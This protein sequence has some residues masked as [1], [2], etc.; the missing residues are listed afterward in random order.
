MVIDHLFKAVNFGLSDETQVLLLM[1]GRMAFPFFAWELVECF[2]FTK[3]K[4]KH[5]FSIGLLAT[6]SE[7]PYDRAIR[8]SW[9][10]WNRQNIC[11]TLFL[12]WLMLMLLHADWNK[13]YTNLGMTKDTKLKRAFAK[14]SGLSMAAPI[15]WVAGKTQA[16]YVWWGIGFVLLLDFAH[17][18]KF[19]KVW[20]FIT[21]VTYIGCMGLEDSIMRMVYMPCFFCLIFMWLAELDAKKPQK[22]NEFVSKMLLSKTS[23]T[24]CR[25]FYPAHLIILLILKGVLH[26]L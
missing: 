9:F 20:E 23:K 21:I 2:H 1:I 8:N 19:R 25:Y 3:N 4:W 18:R 24:I 11:L 13:I 16:D 10:D 14:M 6:V 12:S 17:S 7:I 5:L 26:Q 15:M 22:K